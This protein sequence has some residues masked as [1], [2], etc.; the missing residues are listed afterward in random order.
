ME[1]AIDALEK[2]DLKLITRRRMQLSVEVFFREFVPVQLLTL[3][4][5]PRKRVVEDLRFVTRGQ[6]VG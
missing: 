6:T 4:S 3:H 1:P 2:M 5:A